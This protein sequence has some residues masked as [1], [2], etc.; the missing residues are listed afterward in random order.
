M[1]SPHESFHVPNPLPDESLFPEV[2]GYLN[3]SNG[4]P[5]PRLRGL[6]RCNSCLGVASP[7]ATS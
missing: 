4:K 3:F 7:A 1:S 2:L 6:G 5:D